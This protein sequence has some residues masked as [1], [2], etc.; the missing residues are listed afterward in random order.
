M[1]NL[2]KRGKE[3]HQGESKLDLPGYWVKEIEV[4][5]WELK[6]GNEVHTNNQVSMSL[7]KNG[8]RPHTRKVTLRMTK[9]GK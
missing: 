2:G 6:L 9:F 8:V 5:R 3:V 4:Q 1:F 7:E